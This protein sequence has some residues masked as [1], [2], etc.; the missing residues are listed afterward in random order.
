MVQHRMESF[1]QKQMSIDKLT[2]PGW[3]DA[4]N[5]FHE[6]DMKYRTTELKVPAVVKPPTDTPAA[7]P[8][9]TTFGEHMPV[10]HIVPGQSQMPQVTS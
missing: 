2:Q 7:T 4:A 1:R 9:P 10:L 5:H 8:S 3:G 6:R